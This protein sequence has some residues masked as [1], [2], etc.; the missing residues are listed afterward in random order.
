M[1]RQILYIAMV[2]VFTFVI[3]QPY[4]NLNAAELWNSPSKGKDLGNKIYN[5][6]KAYEAK[7]SLYNRT[8]ENKK[9]QFNHGVSS[10]RTSKDIK[11]S[12]Q[13]PSKLWEI[14][15]ASEL[16]N[17]QA[18][19]DFALEQ[20]YNIKKKTAILVNK[21]I[22]DNE[23]R[24]YAAEKRYQK[25]L[26]KYELEELSDKAER[27]ERKYRSIYSDSHKQLRR[28]SKSYKSSSSNNKSG[29]KPK[30]LFNTRY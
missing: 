28:V 5:Q 15:P 3:F 17:R 25:D 30:K 14:M 6:R 19:I 8:N 13:Y 22:R 1:K 12:K 4:M 29:N 23:K 7:K 27:L 9:S 18:D 10:I 20:E 16:E 26:A 24:Q 2:S 21:V 11:M